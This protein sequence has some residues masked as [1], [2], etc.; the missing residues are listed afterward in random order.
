MRERHTPSLRDPAVKQES[1]T[2]LAMSLIRPRQGAANLNNN[3]GASPQIVLCLRRWLSTTEKAHTHT[4]THTHTVN[5]E[6]EG[7]QSP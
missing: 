3:H 5:Y 1:K 7:V 4:H 2:L 6:G